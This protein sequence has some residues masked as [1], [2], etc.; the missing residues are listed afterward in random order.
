MHKTYR[1]MS[2]FCGALFLTEAATSTT[3][4]NNLSNSVA[5]T[6]ELSGQT[7]V[8]ASF[9]TDAS[10]YSFSG[11]TLLISG[12]SGSSVSLQLFS[13]AFSQPGRPLLTL[14]A[15]SPLSPTLTATS[16]DSPHYMLS[17]KTTYWA[18]LTATSGTAEWAYTNSNSGSGVGFQHTWAVTED[19]G[20]DWLTFNSYPMLFSASA[21]P[22]P[23]A[24]SPE[25][26][27]IF[28]ILLGVLVL[29]SWGS[30]FTSIRT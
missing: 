14:S 24:V 22:I 16:F 9:A 25:P 4:S 8:A 2:I 10:A 23:P 13:D 11:M 20:A 29:C 30:K 26:A 27:S 15:A 17:S 19:A 5:G 3:L 18:V 21:A 1:L 7:W 6:E 12:T 28:L